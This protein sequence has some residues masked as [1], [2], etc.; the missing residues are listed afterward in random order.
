MDKRNARDVLYVSVHVD[1]IGD[2][3]PIDY[4]VLWPRDMDYCPACKRTP[5]SSA[6]IYAFIRGYIHEMFNG[7]IAPL[8]R[9]LGYK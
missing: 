4:D 2:V 3:R 5:H 8:E 6:E 1:G 7:P 9:V